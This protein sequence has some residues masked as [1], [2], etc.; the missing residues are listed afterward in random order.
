MSSNL[1]AQYRGLETAKD[2][3]KKRDNDVD[4]WT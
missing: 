2:N 3:K 4:E 1:Q